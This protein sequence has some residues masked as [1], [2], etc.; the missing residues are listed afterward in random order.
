MKLLT[1][2][3][4][5]VYENYRCD[6]CLGVRYHDHMP[7]R[8]LRVLGVNANRHVS[9]REIVYCAHD[10]TTHDMTVTR[11][12][13]AR[14]TIRFGLDIVKEQRHD[15][16]IFYLWSTHG[17]FDITSP[18]EEWLPGGGPPRLDFAEWCAPYDNSSLAG[19]T[20]YPGEVQA[21]PTSMG[22]ALRQPL[23][24]DGSA[25]VQ[26]SSMQ[27]TNAPVLRNQQRQRE[28][29]LQCGASITDDSARGTG[30]GFGDPQAQRAFG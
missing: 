2:R 9:L 27:G 25:L 4:Q 21:E 29:C 1:Y 22:E 7:C 26:P 18:W 13:I 5:T 28:R 23:R 30:Q 17:R 20:V 14:I 12:A 19:E 10:L 8:A 16:S 11:R 24:N 6:P 15:G 3:R